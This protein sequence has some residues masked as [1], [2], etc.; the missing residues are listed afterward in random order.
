MDLCWQS[1]VAKYKTPMSTKLQCL[2][3]SSCGLLLCFMSSLFYLLEGCSCLDLGPTLMQSDLTSTSL[4]YYICKDPKPK[5]HHIMRF[6]WMYLLV[7][8]IHKVRKRMRNMASEKHS[9][10]VTPTQQQRLFSEQQTRGAS[11][12]LG[13]VRKKGS[14]LLL[15]LSLPD[16]R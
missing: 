5:Q 7:P 16:D 11:P 2:P 10:P 14:S 4:P 13:S 3:L 12:S 9:R 8:V 6:G 15:G 1:D